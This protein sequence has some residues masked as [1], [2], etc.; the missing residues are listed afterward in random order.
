MDPNT[1]STHVWGKDDLDGVS[2]NFTQNAKVG[3]EITIVHALDD[4]HVS[5]ANVDFGQKVDVKVGQTVSSS[6]QQVSMIHD[7]GYV[8]VKHGDYVSKMNMGI[9]QDPT[10]SMPSKPSKPNQVGVSP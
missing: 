7:L 8:L 3:F 10:P 5:Y 4:S 1:T 2:M 6:S 9:K